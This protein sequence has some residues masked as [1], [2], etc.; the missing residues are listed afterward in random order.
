MNRSAH[1][2]MAAWRAFQW[3]NTVVM[4]T[5]EREM[6]THGLSITW[7]DVLVHLAEAPDGRLRMQE[8]AGSVVLSGSGTTR[9]IDRM[10]IAGLVT[11]EPSPG[12]RRGFYTVISG[13]GR[14]ELDRIWPLHAQ[15]IRE[16]FTSLLTDEQVPVL[17]E[18]MAAVI[19]ANEG[20]DS[21]YA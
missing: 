19:R 14:R 18:A 16:H 20:P 4:R 21:F 8:L 1:D 15:G 12:D 5:L 3:A 13:A 11:R 17:Y 10:E 9:L 7:F 2:R 6:E